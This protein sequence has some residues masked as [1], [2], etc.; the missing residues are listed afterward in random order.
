MTGCCIAFAAIV[1]L[2]LVIGAKLTANI[3]NVYVGNT[4]P[5]AQLDAIRTSAGNIRIHV[6]KALAHRDKSWT[7]QSVRAIE[8]DLARLDAAWSDYYPSGIASAEEQVAADV[9]KHQI[10]EVRQSVAQG[11]ALLEAS[12]DQEAAQWMDRNAD[13][14]NAFDA[15]LAHDIDVNLRDAQSRA[16]DSSIVFK[17][18]FVVGSTLLTITCALAAIAIWYLLRKR[19]NDKR[20]SRY[21]LW[22]ASRVFEHTSNGVFVV[23]RHGL[24]ERIN[25]GFTTLTQYELAHVQGHHFSLL[26]AG[27][28]T[29]QFYEELWQQL[30]DSGHW[31]GEVWNRR[32][33]GELYLESM[34]MSGIRDHRGRYSHFVAICNDVTQRRLD[35]DRLSYLATHDVLTGLLNR[36]QFCEHLQQALANARR[37][38]TGTAVM[39]IDL[40][41]FKKINDTLGHGVGDEVLKAVGSR[42]AQALRASDAVARFGGD[43]FTVLLEDIQDSGGTTHVAEALLSAVGAPMHIDGSTLQVTPSIGISLFPEHGATPDALL[44]AADMAMYRA[45]SSGK[46]GF[47]LA[48]PQ[49]GE[50]AAA[51]GQLRL[52]VTE[53]VAEAA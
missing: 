14:L 19:G 33:G 44:L 47:R 6:W 13:L 30:N 22:M 26:N 24:I 17:K 43:E 34:S 7:A 45:K 8:A 11:V 28:Q 23:D 40:D 53:P 18:A 5:V 27:R 36:P 38:Q 9:L 3:K 12:R 46:N 51:T 1:V 15:S 52:E 42:I 31:K 32:K 21:H 39:F 49:P 35:E 29:P 4:A 48:A 2:S 20:E 10:A 37:R 50:G 41:G 16:L 25:P